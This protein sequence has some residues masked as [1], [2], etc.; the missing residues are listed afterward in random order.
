MNV[1]STLLLACM[2]GTGCVVDAQEIGNIVEGEVFTSTKSS[3]DM[4]QLVWKLYKSNK[5]EEAL[6]LIDKLIAQDKTISAYYEL[7]C[8]ILIALK[9][10]T[11]IIETATKGI[12][13]DPDNHS[14]YD[15]RGNT[16]YFDLKP[17]L[18]RSDYQKVLQLE[19]NN[20][21]YY[22]NYLKLLNEMRKD[23][24]LINVFKLFEN[25]MVSGE[26]IKE[27]RFI[28]DVYFYGALAYQRQKDNLRAVELL[29]N[30]IKK[31]PEAAMYYNN[32]GLIF[33]DLNKL[34]AAKKDLDKAIELDRDNPVYYENRY[35]I[36]FDL[37]KYQ[38]A[39][40]DLLKVISLG[41]SDLDIYASLALTYDVL[42]NYPKAAEY[43][44]LVLRKNPNQTMILSNYAYALF[45][46]NQISKAIEMFE[47]A[48]VTDPAEVDILV[49]LAVLY[50]VDGKENK[51]KDLF[52]DIKIKTKYEAKKQL[53][54]TLEKEDYRFSSKFKAAWENCFSD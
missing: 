27:P 8:Y 53:L 50:H 48:L 23:D 42:N 44:D 36:F 9:R 20:A 26:D 14:F 35:A 47:R 1:V 21:R 18:A 40:N 43:Y 25:S 49:G 54:E 12:A 13:L 32:R 39:Q 2:L 15:I 33:Q 41:N 5:H 11:T 22:N 10:N 29:G 51:S 16:Y 30:A 6:K 52:Q 7:K 3:E 38:E 45:E 34:E 28:A 46:L 4:Y 24:E 17:E 31:S 19:K 37:K